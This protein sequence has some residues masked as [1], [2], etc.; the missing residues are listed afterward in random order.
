MA[1][2]T[3]ANHLDRSVFERLADM[4][5]MDLL[6]LKN[7][8]QQ[9]IADIKNRISIATQKLAEE[10]EYADRDWWRRVHTALRFRGRVD[11]AIAL[12]LR[13]RKEARKQATPSATLEGTLRFERAFYKIAKERLSEDIFVE[14]VLEAKREANADS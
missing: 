8:N 7:A 14:L 2:M 5:D 9:N 4:S 6:T 1:T 12:E 13:K 10:G 11:Q 3:R